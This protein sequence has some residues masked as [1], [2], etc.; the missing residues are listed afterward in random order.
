M[1][2]A[3]KGTNLKRYIEE[4]LDKAAEDCNDVEMYEYLLKVAPEGKERVSEQE[5]LEF[6]DWLGL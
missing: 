4:L 1:A 6:E 5:K 3:R 2:A